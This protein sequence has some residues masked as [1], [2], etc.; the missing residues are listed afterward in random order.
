MLRISRGLDGAL[1]KTDCHARGGKEMFDVNLGDALECMSIR[2]LI[3]E[4]DIVIANAG[5][6][7]PKSTSLEQNVKDF[8][9]WRD[10]LGKN[11][12]IG[13]S[14]YCVVCRQGPG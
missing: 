9:E 8:I 1:N 12:S 14:P 13:P 2:G 10:G 3:T 4:S 7:H 5:I 6:H 11:S